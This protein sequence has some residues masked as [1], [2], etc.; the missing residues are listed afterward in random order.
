MSLADTPPLR[1]A[2]L[3][4]E[5]TRRVISRL[6]EAGG[7]AWFVGGCV[8][9]SLLAPDLDDVKLDIDITTD[10]LPQRVMEACGRD[11]MKAVPTGIAHGTV[12][13][14]AGGRPF[15]VTTLRR[16]VATD[17][18]HAKV[19]F[20]TEIAE[21]AQRRDFTINAL[22]ALPDGRILDPLGG[23]A[24]LAASRVRF[25]GDPDRRIIE[26]HLR[27]LRFFRFHARFGTG[28]PDHDGLAACIR[29]REK[30]K[31]LSF[32]RIAQELLKLL[33][34]PR[35]VPCLAIM[36]SSGILHAIGLDAAMPERLEELLRLDVEA[37][38]VLRLAALFR[39]D[40]P[41]PGA[42]TDLAVSLKLATAVRDRLEAMLGQPLPPVDE[43]GAHL[44]RRW[45]LEG[46]PSWRDRFLLAAARHS[47]E[48]SAVKAVLAEAEQWEKPSFPIGGKD[49][50]ALGVR[51][52]PE[53]RQR[54]QTALEWWLDQDMRPDRESCLAFL[55]GASP[56]L[57]NHP[58]TS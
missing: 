36:K 3:H 45:Y 22:Y 28:D 43:H 41:V 21:D 24:D 16:D 47:V 54:L 57:T 38:P 6:Q 12:T 46:V 17:G 48:M 39:Q 34:A 55:A 23:L 29:H 15:E 2:W 37:D 25:I 32:E 19:A 56:P 58:R 7:R 42:G 4:A 33:Q 9:D 11:G 49:V 27:I 5:P 18:R 51:P 50:L 31:I 44:R 1:S 13:V 14:V 53:V 40:D 52:G 20:G 35:P 26:D 8:R 30:L 10:L